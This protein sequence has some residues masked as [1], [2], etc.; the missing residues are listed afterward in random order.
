MM[1]RTYTQS[2]LSIN[3]SPKLRTPIAYRLGIFLLSVLYAAV[4]TCLPLDI[5]MDRI[6]YLTYAEYSF[7]I[8]LRLWEAGLLPMITNEPIWLLMN[9]TLAIVLPP[10]ITVRVI[11]FV[12][13][14]LVSYYVLST[15]PRNFVWLLLV[16]HS[17]CYQESHHPFATRCCDRS[18]SGCLVF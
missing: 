7:D 8:F 3:P 16:A 18:I 2:L 11:I 4:L 10:E 13:A 15:K 9:S 6:N 12:P 14:V 17:K 1:S 5:F